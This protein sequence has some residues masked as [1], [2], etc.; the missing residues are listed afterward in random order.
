MWDNIKSQIKYGNRVDLMHNSFNKPTIY[1]S[2]FNLF[3]TSR[4]NAA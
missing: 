3:V 4:V 1:T 2:R